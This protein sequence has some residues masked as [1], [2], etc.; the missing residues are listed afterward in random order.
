VQ[1]AEHAL[2]PDVVRIMYSFAE[3]V[4]GEISLFFRIVI[5]DHAAVESR[6]RE[7]TKRVVSRIL[8]ETNARELGLQTY[9]NFRSRSEQAL[10]RDPFWERQ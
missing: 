10:L 3:D 7:T 1:R 5:S 9:F 6:L 4:Q 8:A 2:A